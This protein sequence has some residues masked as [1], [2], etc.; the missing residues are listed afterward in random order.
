M[1][2]NA[3]EEMLE[4]V[5]TGGPCGKAHDAS[6]MSCEERAGHEAY[7]LRFCTICLVQFAPHEPHQRLCSYHLTQDDIRD[8][9]QAHARRAWGGDRG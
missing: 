3:I 4:R 9:A 5:L 7:A 6:L 1:A 2:E 8:R